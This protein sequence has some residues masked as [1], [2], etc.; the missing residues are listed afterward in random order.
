MSSGKPSF[1]FIINGQPVF[2]KGANWIP[3]DA[4]LPRVTPEKYDKL[5]TMAKTA[6]INMLRVWG[7]GIYENNVFYELCDRM[8]LMVWQDFMF[9]CGHYPEHPEFISNIKEEVSQNINRLQYHPSVAIWCGNNENEWGWFMDHGPPVKRMPGFKIFHQII[10]KILKNIDPLRPYWPT[11]P[12]GSDP[13]PNS[14]KNGNH[15]QWDIWSSGVDYSEVKSNKSLFVSEFGFQGPANRETFEK[16]L[17]KSDWHPDAPLFLFHNKQHGGSKL[18][19]HFLK[20]HLPEQHSWED[21]IYLTQLNQGFALK[22]CLEHWRSHW[23]KTAGSIIWQLNDC[24]PVTSWSLIDSDLNPKLSYYFVK[25]A[26]C[27]TLIYFKRK[28]TSAEMY[29]LNSSSNRFHGIVTLHNLD[30][31]TGT[32]SQIEVFEL[33][34]DENMSKKLYNL[35]QKIQGDS[36]DCLI[37][38][39]LSD[40]NNR[41]IHRNYFLS[42]RWKNVALPDTQVSMKLVTEKASTQ[43]VVSSENPAFFVDFY[44]PRVRFSDRGFILLP[45]E[46]KKLAVSG[47]QI[48]KI[49][50]ADIE[51]YSLNNYLN[52]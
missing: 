52:S 28:N 30:L 3:S 51:V 45:G 37:M 8:G 26:Y 15:H 36:K 40:L 20:C 44:H 48:E 2:I 18:L 11:S 43:L 4:F 14:E 23:P 27:D 50:I 33:S 35:E 19:D 21:F 49:N 16:A 13:D 22:T 46:E 10:P 39:T 32:V 12:F 29:L 34:L 6:G 25:Q 7:G 41:I 31:K 1:R 42:T 38:A 17:P 5:L 9:A 47:E 24:W